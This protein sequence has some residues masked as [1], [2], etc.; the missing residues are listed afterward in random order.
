M[1]N[2]GSTNKNQYMMAATLEVVQQNILDY[3]RISFMVAGHTK[4]APDQLFSLT[5]RDFYASDVFN[6]RE[7]IA[8]MERHTSVMFDTGGIVRAW[9]ETVI[10]KYSNLPG[11]RG[12]HDFLALR[13][14]GEHAVMKVRER[15][16]SGTLQA[17]PMKITKGMSPRDR[18][19]PGVSI[20]C[21]RDGQRPLREQTR[22]FEPNVFQ[23]HPTR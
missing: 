10:K 20:S 11:I 2:A 18:A 5:T 7:M 12:L 3:F 13:N 21:P 9:R 16:Y 6:E 8:V 4:F 19:L 17:T 14:S 23:L 1:D 15:C 22:A